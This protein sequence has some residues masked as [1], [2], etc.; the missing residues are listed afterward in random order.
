MLL[1]LLAVQ[2]FPLVVYFVQF[3]GKICAFFLFESLLG[4]SE[5]L[6]NLVTKLQSWQQPHDMQISERK[7]VVQNTS[8]ID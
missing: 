4:S 2:W 8:L 5:K 6:L 3:R 7:L 1:G